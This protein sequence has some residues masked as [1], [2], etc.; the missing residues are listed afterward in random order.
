MDLHADVSTLPLW[1][2]A[3][4]GL[5]LIAGTG[6]LFLFSIFLVVDIAANPRRPHSCWVLLP[7]AFAMGHVVWEIRASGPIAKTRWVLFLI[8][9]G[10]L[11]WNAWTLIRDPIGAA[12]F[13]AWGV[14]SSGL[15][16]IARLIARGAPARKDD[17]Q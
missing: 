2:R 13:A 5:C 4:Y 3:T 12:F 10:S 8:A 9:T 14:A 1:K 7:V 15:I 17:I 6:G 16:F 11:A